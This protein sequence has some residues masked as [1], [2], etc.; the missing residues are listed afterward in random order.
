MKRFAII[1][2]AV[3]SVCSCGKNL[4]GGDDVVPVEWQGYVYFGADV[5]TKTPIYKDLNGQHYGVIA[6]KYDYDW[7]TFKAV[8]KPSS[9]AGNGT[10][11]GFIFPTEVTCQSSGLCTY[12]SENGSTPVEWE[13]GKVYSF[14]AYF[15]YSAA[16]SGNGV[17]LNSNAESAGVPSIK[18]T[19]PSWSDPSSLSDVMTAAAIDEV[20]SGDG[21][22]G[23]TF[24]HRL[25]CLN[26][27]ARNFNN[28]AETVKNL[29]IN[30]TSE[31]F[32]SAVIPLDPDI[33][34][35]QSG[36]HT[37]AS[38]QIIPDSDA[39]KV[40]VPVYD[41]ISSS[42]TNL[43]GDNNIILIPQNVENIMGDTNGDGVDEIILPGKGKLAGD[44]SFTDKNGNPQSQ[45]F[46]SDKNFE[47]GKKYTFVITFA[48]GSISIAIIESGEWTDV[49]QDIIFE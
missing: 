33:D 29:K 46:E 10:D 49:N 13:Q 5:M 37:G 35:V 1:V 27:E 43:S 15:P 26:V 7:N 47:P 41:G 20:N 23:F 9:A 11:P 45:E 44:I 6:F 4:Q 22:V 24:K 28:S 31:M 3:M 17:I 39:S 48:N 12:T 34:I 21:T 14:F 19:T 30:I 16:T 38:Y 2:L 25:C 36:S 32:E 42:T 8:G 18:Y 40:T